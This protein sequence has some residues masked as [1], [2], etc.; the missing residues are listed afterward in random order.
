M[1]RLLIVCAA[2]ALVLPLTACNQVA[3]PASGAH[4][5]DVKVIQD[6]ET[7]WVADWNSKDAGKIAAHYTDDA[8]LM[9]PGMDAASGK[10]AINK[11]LGGMVADPTMSLKFHADHVDVA[12]AGDMAYT[13]GAYTVTYTD[14]Q[15]KQ[16][17]ND[18]GSYVT[19]YKKAADGAWKVVSDIASSAIPISPPAPAKAMK[20]TKKM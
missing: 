8:V 18:H 17:I 9:I 7:Q 11:S 20:P 19:V 5:A 6:G 3:A 12:S 2:T 10:D 1:N 16:V 15:S 13:Q 14:T 4:D